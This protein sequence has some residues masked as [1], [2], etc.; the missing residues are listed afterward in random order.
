MS[1]SIDCPNCDQEITEELS[2]VESGDCITCPHCQAELVVDITYDADGD[3]IMSLQIS[4]VAVEPSE[5]NED[6]PDEDASDEHILDE[7]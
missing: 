7:D 2:E 1:V 5:E 3:E 4:D 6:F